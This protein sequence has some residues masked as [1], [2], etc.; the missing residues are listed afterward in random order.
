M[1]SR[2]RALLGACGVAVALT[3]GGAIGPGGMAAL[4]AGPPPPPAPQPQP[5]GGCTLVFVQSIDSWGCQSSD[6]AHKPVDLNGTSS[7]GQP[8]STPRAAA[9][10]GYYYSDSTGLVAV[11]GRNYATFN[12]LLPINGRLV[13]GG[14]PSQYT[15]VSGTG[16]HVMV[17]T[18]NL[19]SV[20]LA[21]YLVVADYYQNVQFV[22]AVAAVPATSASAG[23]PPVAATPGSPA[24]PAKCVNTGGAQFKGLFASPVCPQAGAA[25]CGAPGTNTQQ[26]KD[27]YNYLVNTYLS[28]HLAGGQVTTVP[29]ADALVG[30]PTNVSLKGANLPLSETFSVS[31]ASTNTWQGRAL[32]LTLNVSLSLTEV[33]YNWGDGVNSPAYGL[34]ATGT[35]GMGSSVQHTYYDVSVHGEHPTPY[36]VINAK[37]QIPVTAYG[38]EQL[39][40]TLS[41]TYPWGSVGSE[42]LN[43]LT[44]FVP[45]V[46]AGVSS[47]SL[48]PPSQ[49]TLQAHASW[50]VIG[51]IESIPVC[52]TP[53]NCS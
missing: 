37:D 41:W 22:P 1:C 30:L 12:P 7:N 15:L 17:S 26:V 39:T 29:A 24:V 48:T 3:L 25:L 8:D 36:P 43:P 46:G 40:A 19:G 2:V 13:W 42:N 10:V 32:V 52:P 51:Q 18:R 53:T 38:I 5:T 28:G 33:V 16:G 47:I 4:A 11:V 45:A 20:S 34:S 21:D 9:C 23:P 50:I 44:M 35:P 49:A 27:M 6:P 31:Q 14:G